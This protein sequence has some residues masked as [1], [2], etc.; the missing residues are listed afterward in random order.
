MYH[1]RSLDRVDEAARLPVTDV[2]AVVVVRQRAVVAVADR[3]ELL[4]TGA[5]V[6]R[7]RRVLRSERMTMM[8]RVMGT[9]RRMRNGR[10]E[11]H[12]ERHPEQEHADARGTP[13]RFE[14]LRLV[15]TVELD[16]K[17]LVLFLERLEALDGGA[18]LVAITA[19]AHRH[20][21]ADP[22]RM[23]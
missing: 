20:T 21:P 12:P 16:A 7:A 10:G 18:D 19:V 14:P 15:E 2:V 1:F 8:A 5:D 3:R 9:R 17:T 6:R 23:S 4:R 22:P 11:R 13:S